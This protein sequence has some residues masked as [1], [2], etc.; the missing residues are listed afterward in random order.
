MVSLYD[1]DS[2]M[3]VLQLLAITGTALLEEARYVTE[4]LH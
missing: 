1:L 2:R 4:N 3:L